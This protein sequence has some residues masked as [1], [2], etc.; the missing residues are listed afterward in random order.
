LGGDWYCRVG[1]ENLF[2][3]EKPNARLGIGMDALPDPIRNS[4]ILSGNQ[5][6][7]L[8]N[9]HE[10]PVVDAAFEDERLTSI[11]QYYSVSPVEMEKEL[12]LY[13][14]ALLDA[15]KVREAWQVLLALA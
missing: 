6:G 8:A 7:Q 12:H 1:P 3:V 4:N 10:L 15:G 9:V 14:A 11:F 13:A 5:L 2:A